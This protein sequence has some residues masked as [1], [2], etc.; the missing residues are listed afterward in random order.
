MATAIS[1]K[2]DI[3]AL[4]SAIEAKKGGGALPKDAGM[5]ALGA[6]MQGLGKGIAEKGSPLPKDASLVDLFSKMPPGSFHKA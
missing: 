4:A 1:G 6:L 3:S 5:Q 2:I